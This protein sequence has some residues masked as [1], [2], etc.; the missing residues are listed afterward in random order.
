MLP[1]TEAGNNRK[2]IGFGRMLGPWENEFSCIG[3]RQHKINKDIQ[4]E[5]GPCPNPHQS[6]FLPSTLQQLIFNLTY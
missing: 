1:L 3:Q 2:G 5:I 6:C 4:Q